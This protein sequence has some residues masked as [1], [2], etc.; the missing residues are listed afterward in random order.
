MHF[1]QIGFVSRSAIRNLANTN[2]GG[3]TMITTRFLFLAIA[4]TTCGAVLATEDSITLLTASGNVKLGKGRSVIIDSN[5]GAHY[6]KG[7]LEGLSASRVPP[8]TNE[9]FN[10]LNP[11]TQRHA[12]D[13][14]QATIR[15][16]ESARQAIEKGGIE[17]SLGWTKIP[18]GDIEEFL[19]PCINVACSD[20]SRFVVIYSKCSA[21]AVLFAINED[22]K[23]VW[24]RQ[25][26]SEY[27]DSGATSC[28]VEIVVTGE[29]LFLF[30]VERY[31]LSVQ[32]FAIDDGECIDRIDFELR[33]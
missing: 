24:K 8:A 2:G 3:C 30:I 20:K 7:F 22:G 5:E 16:D 21:A 32:R 4:I 1:S 33:P 12:K 10:S 17:T 15:H 14:N 13:L 19:L 31:D 25:L 6:V 9:F 28:V 29:Q 11:L 27:F 18:K 23:A 26:D